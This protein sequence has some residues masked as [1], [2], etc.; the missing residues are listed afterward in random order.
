MSKKI[1]I[2]PSL[3]ASNWGAF[4][5][6]AQMAVDAGADWL[7]FDVMDGQF[8]PP[9]TFGADVVAAVKSKV[10]VFADV[11]LMIHT[12]ERQLQDFVKAGADLIS[13]HVETCPHLHRTIGEIRE[14]GI[15][16]G[17][18]INPA[19]P[20]DL[21][22]EI[23]RDVDLLLVMS[24]NPGWGGQQFLPLALEKIS[25]IK[26]LADKHNPDL[27]IEVDGGVNATTARDI[28]QA[29]ANVLVA[30]N[31]VFK[32]PDYAKAISEIRND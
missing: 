4:V 20:V 18:A 1:I 7:H 15:K 31:A 26:A 11:H 25:A 9:I 10:N 3:L 27:L 23:I 6:E 29:G 30:G 14:H 2:A 5:E 21:I 24:V 22:K 19:T 13:V 32:E 28:I 8:V 17:V 16:A 12:P